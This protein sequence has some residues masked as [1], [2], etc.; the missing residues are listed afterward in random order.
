MISVIHGSVRSRL[1]LSLTQQRLSLAHS[2]LM[3]ELFADHA[4]ASVELVSCHVRDLQQHRRHQI[5]TLQQLQVNVHVERHLNT[6]HTSLTPLL[7]HTHTSLTP[8]LHHTH[9]TSLTPLLHHTHT[10][11]TYS[12][13]APHTHTHTHTHTTYSITAPH[14][15][16][17]LLYYTSLTPLI[18]SD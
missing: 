11:T 9:I 16:R 14:T 17:L 3:V 12:F 1:S 4:A 15:H 2:K 7:H 5:H 13:T 10:H 18:I 8:L 6:T